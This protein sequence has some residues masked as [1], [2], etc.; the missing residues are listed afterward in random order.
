MGDNGRG[1]LGSVGQIFGG[2]T[3]SFGGKTYQNYYASV[4]SWANLGYNVFDVTSS[5]NP[6]VYTPDTCFE[7]LSIGSN[8]WKAIHNTGIAVGGDG[9]IVTDKAPGVHSSNE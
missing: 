9:I 2:C 8:R 5:F 1:F 4:N 7:L 6:G 3:P